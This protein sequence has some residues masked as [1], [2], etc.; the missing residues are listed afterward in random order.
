MKIES[1]NLTDFDL[2]WGPVSLSSLEE[3]NVNHPEPEE[4]LQAFAFILREECKR[5]KVAGLSECVHNMLKGKEEEL[6]LPNRMKG[7]C[8]CGRGER[9]S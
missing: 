2:I 1:C 5:G 7:I 9:S 3:S 4:M 6:T 8:T